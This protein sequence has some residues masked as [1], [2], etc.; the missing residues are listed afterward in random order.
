MAPYL[1]G[2]TAILPIHDGD[3]MVENVYNSYCVNYYTLNI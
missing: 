2:S 3:E 1:E